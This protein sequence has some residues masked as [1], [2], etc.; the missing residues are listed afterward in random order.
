MEI[1]RRVHPNIVFMDIR[2]PVMDGM[3]AMQRLLEDPGKAHL[4]VVAVSASTLEH[5]RQ[6]YLEA[7]FDEFIGKPVRVD[8]LYRCM[9]ELLGVEYEYAEQRTEPEE[10]KPL[11]LEGMSLPAQ[12]HDRLQAAATVANVTELRQAIEEVAQ[13]DEAEARL[14]RHLQQKCENFDMAAIL[15][16][17]ELV[18]KS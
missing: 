14:A 18:K 12:L 17:L 10:E 7:G 11:E 5:E 16:A 4:K 1:G 6:H 2:M 3:E 15:Q 13:L 8:Q 9:A